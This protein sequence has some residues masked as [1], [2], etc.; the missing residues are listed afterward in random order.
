[1]NSRYKSEEFENIKHQRRYRIRDLETNKVVDDARGYGYTSGYKAHIA[2]GY[3]IR[4]K[5]K[6]LEKRKKK[7]EIDAW[8][9]DHEDF[10]KKIKESNSRINTAIL[11]QLLKQ[12]DLE[13]PVHAYDL[14]KV[15][16]NK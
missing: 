10:V 16:Q 1:M 2:W 14:L 13:I 11:K 9:K 15:I 4:D 6:D 8:I 5:S 12:N 3:K 7:Q